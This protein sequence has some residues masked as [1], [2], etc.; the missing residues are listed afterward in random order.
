MPES[1]VYDPAR[2]ILYIS[3][4][5]QYGTPG[6][7]CIS[8]VS[9]DGELLEPCWVQGLVNP[10]G[11][12]IYQDKLLVVERKNVAEIDLESGHIENRYQV[13]DRERCSGRR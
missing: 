13:P 4:L 9:P 6:S 1:V 3:N 10:T 7:Q 12:A 8:K 5:D 2:K 11:L